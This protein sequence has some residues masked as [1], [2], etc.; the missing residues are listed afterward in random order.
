MTALHQSA[1]GVG[2]PGPFGQ[3]EVGGGCHDKPTNMAPD[4]V[5]CLRNW[6]AA[7]L[8]WVDPYL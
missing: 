7:A 6:P 4:P 1:E 5:I 3:S 8:N 2:P